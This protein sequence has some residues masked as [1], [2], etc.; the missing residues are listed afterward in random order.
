MLKRKI[1]MD[2]DHVMTDINAWFTEIA[3]IVSK[4]ISMSWNSWSNQKLTLLKMIRITKRKGQPNHQQKSNYFTKQLTRIPTVNSNHLNMTMENAILKNLLI[5]FVR[6]N[7]RK[8]IPFH[9]E[10]ICHLQLDVNLH[11][12][13]LT[14]LRVAYD[15]TQKQK[16]LLHLMIICIYLWWVNHGRNC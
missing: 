8:Q 4:M 2:I 9:W 5:I 7:T 14:A 1:S 12:T 10:V 15:L 13:L 16:M 11:V 3:I 6:R